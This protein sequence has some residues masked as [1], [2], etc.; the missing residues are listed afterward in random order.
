MKTK[1]ITFLFTT[2][3]VFGLASCNNMDET[4]RKTKT[5][6]MGAKFY[7]D[8]LNVKT[9]QYVTLSY[10]PKTLTAKG[11][12]VDS[13][14]Y[15][16]KENIGE[17]KLP[18][19]KLKKQSSFSIGFNEKYDTITVVY[20]N[21]ND[22]LSLECGCVPTHTIDTVLTTNHVIDKIKI[23]QPNINTTY[24]ENIKIYLVK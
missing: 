10:T 16:K 3:V 7:Q 15:N 23:S 9:N 13:I 8:T 21:A 24:V 12:G 5:V 22:Y 20:Q 18:L 6:L 4:C 1:H 17:I 14:L 11:V 19:N 2:L